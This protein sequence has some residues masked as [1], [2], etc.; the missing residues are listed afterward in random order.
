MLCVCV[1]GMYGVDGVCVLHM[2][3]RESWLAGWLASVLPCQ[4]RSAI[5]LTSRHPPILMLLWLQSCCS[6]PELIARCIDGELL[7]AIPSCPEPGCKGKLRLEGGKVAC[8]GAYNE[9]IGSFVR[10]YYSAQASAITRVPWKESKPS[11]GE[12]EISILFSCRGLTD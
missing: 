1:C 10:C 7:G 4:G 12:L 6:Q 5:L 8:G 2:R 9:E 11:D 3:E